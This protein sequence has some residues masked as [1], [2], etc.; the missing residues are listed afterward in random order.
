MYLICRFRGYSDER[1]IALSRIEQV[2][3]L[4]ERFKQP[5]EFS[6]KGFV[7]KGR[8]GYGD[9]KMSKIRLRFDHRRGEQLFET[10]LSHDQEI[11]EE[12]NDFLLVTATI[13]ITPQLK[14]WL[15]GFG[16]EVEVIEPAALRRDVIQ[17]ISAMKK[18][19][20]I[21]KE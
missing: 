1:T 12:G 3:L 18:R 21:V 9:S 19:Y 5:D 15:L 10:P 7:E 14:R 17:A 11:I 2:E 4:P 13:P 6:L 16:A 20:E 8:M